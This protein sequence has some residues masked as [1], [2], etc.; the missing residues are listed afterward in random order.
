MPTLMRQIEG[1]FR[2]VFLPPQADAAMVEAAEQENARRARLARRRLYLDGQ[3]YDADN[4]RTMEEN[5][6][7]PLTGRLPEHLRLHAYSTQLAESV[8]FIADQ[9]AG[10]F[11]VLYASDAVAR[12]MAAVARA[13]DQFS[14]DSDSSD[15]VIDDVLLDA[16]SVGDVPVELVWDAVEGTVEWRAWE[17]EEVWIEWLDRTTVER[18]TR[19]ETKWVSAPDGERQVVERT[20]YELVLRDDILTAAGTPVWDCQISVYWDDEDSPVSQRWDN[21]GMIPWRLL[22]VTKKGLRATRGESLVT[23]Q[24]MR[25]ADRYN[26]NEQTAWL[27]ARYNSHA[28]VVVIDDATHLQATVG[29]A[30]G[31]ATSV[32]KDVADVLTLPSGAQAIALE[33]PTDPQMIEHQ[34]AVLS[35]AIYA[36]FGLTRVEPDTI[37]GLGQ[38]SGY[39]LEILNR[40]AEGTLRRIRRVF[41]RDLKDLAHATI[42]YAVYHGWSP[43]QEAPTDPELVSVDTPLVRFWEIEPTQVVPMDARAMEVRMGTGYIVDEAMIREDRTAR[44]ISNREAL[45]QKGYPDEEIDRIERELDEEKAGAALPDSG[46]FTRQG[47][48]GGTVGALNQPD[49]TQ[50]G[51]DGSQ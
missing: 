18:V 31:E 41:T 40:K 37:Q 11:E 46:R 12:L 42:D 50:G 30:A 26:A 29:N 21:S 49:A 44:I 34:R 20:V 27:I 10:R 38:I 22:R 8:A 45:R 43:T 33:L 1:R 32:S 16:C 15:L 28:N 39:A 2:P 48:A 14:G 9:L 19:F 25:H 7:D 36:T 13:S 5:L 24:A 3:Q 35:E 23:E 47:S 17:A 51:P 4:L 6:I